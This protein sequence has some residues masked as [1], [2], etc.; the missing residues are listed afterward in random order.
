MHLKRW[1]TGLTA[2]PFLVLLLSKGGV[3][4]FALVVAA[5][6]VLGLR[7]YFRLVFDPPSHRQPE[8]GG[9]ADAALSSQSPPRF[10]YISYA[11]APAWILT[12]AL[13]T[14]PI[15]TVGTPLVLMMF[16]VAALVTF[17]GGGATLDGLFRHLAG[18]VYIPLLLSHL[19]LIRNSPDGTVWM[20]FLL[21]VVFAG[22]VGAYYAGTYGGK[23]KL[24]PSVSP[25]KTV[26]GAIGGLISN[27]VIGMVFKGLFL[28]AVG[29]HTCFWL[30]LSVGLAG[31]AGDL[32]ESMLK[33]ESGIKDSGKI[34]P[35]HG[36]V[37]DRVDAL[38]FAA[39]VAYWFKIYAV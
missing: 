22:D 12:A 7:E 15:A 30:C 10:R 27:A 36:G 5:V 11:I 23:R 39:P 31:Q 4:W 33:R 35:G 17:K 32:F 19:V 3:I 1:I 2:L 24:C 14:P 18:F 6:S 34:F 20:Y 25:G 8:A 29:W 38:L 13:F 26:E 16:T 21:C 9:S 28:P 37:L